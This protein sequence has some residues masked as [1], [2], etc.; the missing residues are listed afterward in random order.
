MTPNERFG[1]LAWIELL[2]RWIVGLAFILASLHKIL[3]PAAF[4]QI[5][6]SYHLFPDFS[7]NLIAIA[8]PFIELITGLALVAGVYPRAAAAIVSSLLVAFVLII[9]V[10]LLRGHEFDCGCFPTFITR[11]YADSPA[12]MLIRNAVLLA[13]SLPLAFYRGRRRGIFFKNAGT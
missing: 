6:Y 12:N 13:L 8:M 3:Q 10:N 11:L 1:R 4:A 9:A 2:L 7:I 5:V